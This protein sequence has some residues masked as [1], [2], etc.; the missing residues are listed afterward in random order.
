M[1]SV[2]LLLGS[3]MGDKQTFLR[4]SVALLNVSP[5]RVLRTSSLYLSEPWGFVH[6]EKFL[7]QAVEMQ[8]PLEPAELLQ[9]IHVIEN[10]LGRT[11][12]AGQYTARTIDIDILLFGNRI[13]QTPDLTIP[14]P[15][16]AERM[17]V[18]QPL[19][20]LFPDGVHPA[21]QL[22]VE[23]LKAQCADRLQVTKILA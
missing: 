13:I 4:Q 23:Q 10:S 21:L 19:A 11:R 22:T 9:Q 12:V 1:E 5:N 15:R 14:H 7:N 18:L 8:T 6:P 16:M 3:N 17:F 2:F 20:E